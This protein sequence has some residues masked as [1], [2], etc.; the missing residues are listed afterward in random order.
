MVLC[1]IHKMRSCFKPV[2]YVFTV[3]ILLTRP[4]KKGLFSIII[5]ALFVYLTINVPFCNMV[6]CLT[7]YNH[8]FI[9]QFLLKS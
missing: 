8:G 3:A 9:L 5:K 1:S 4:L 6:Q 2:Q 7:Y